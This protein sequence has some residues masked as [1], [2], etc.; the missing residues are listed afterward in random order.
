MVVIL[1]K[2]KAVENKEIRSMLRTANKHITQAELGGE[3]RKFAQAILPSIAGINDLKIRLE[4]L[5]KTLI[6]KNVILEADFQ[7]NYERYE[8]VQ[9]LLSGLATSQYTTKEKVD[10][11]VQFNAKQVD[12]EF[13]V[14]DKHFPILDWLVKN[15]DGLSKEEIKG[16]AESLFNSTPPEIEEALAEIYP[17]TNPDFDAH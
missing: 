2:H 15:P 1:K 7:L 14:T 6:N 11:I 13:K 5:V 10:A 9:N 3:L 8:N 17:E 4:A 12:E 16:Y